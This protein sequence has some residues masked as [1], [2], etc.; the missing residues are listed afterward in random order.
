MAAAIGGF[1]KSLVISYNFDVPHHLQ[2]KFESKSWPAAFSN[3]IAR[4]LI[5][6]LSGLMYAIFMVSAIKMEQ[7]AIAKL[8]V[9]SVVVGYLAPDLWKTQEKRMLD[10]LSRGLEESVKLAF[11]KENKSGG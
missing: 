9:V 7:G 6:A 1:I 4:F 5:G 3:I 2:E 8:I 10:R 11:N